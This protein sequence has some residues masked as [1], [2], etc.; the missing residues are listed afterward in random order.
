MANINLEK[1]LEEVEVLADE[2]KRREYSNRVHNHRSNPSYNPLPNKMSHLQIIPSYEK[3]LEK[4]VEVTDNIV[5]KY[6]EFEKTANEVT[7]KRHTARSEKD[8]HLLT[9]L[10]TETCLEANCLAESTNRMLQCFYGNK[11]DGGAI[12]LKKIQENTRNAPKTRDNKTLCEF[13]RD[14]HD[15]GKYS[16]IR[17]ARIEKA[18]APAEFR[19][20]SS[21]KSEDKLSW[22][23][24]FGELGEDALETLRLQ[25]EAYLDLIKTT[26]QTI[27]GYE[28]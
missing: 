14:I 4:S 15:F 7:S 1:T 24:C 27:I 9:K 13:Y 21:L 5:R 16:L 11:K 10:F 23:P 25:A 3:H 19:I 17:L 20:I 18:H 26:L 12:D 6:R 8:Y 22:T 2:I 28:E